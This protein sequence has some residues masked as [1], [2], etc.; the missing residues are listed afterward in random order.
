MK[1]KIEL[2]I[3]NGYSKYPTP[4]LQGNLLTVIIALNIV[5]LTI[6]PVVIGQFSWIILNEWQ[7][8]T[9]LFLYC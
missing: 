5:I 4:Y 8:N 6:K 2:L 7:Q 9:M 1:D 3:N